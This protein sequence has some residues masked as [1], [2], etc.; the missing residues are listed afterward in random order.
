MGE[1]IIQQAVATRVRFR[2]LA[3]LCVLTFILYLDRVCVGQAGPAIR[4]DLQLSETQLGYVFASFTLAYGL[5]MAAAGRLGDRH[6]SRVVLVV[7]VLW[8]SVFTALTGACTGLAMLLIVRFI[9]GAGEAGALPNCA[10]II[11]R[12]FPAETRGMP[13][14]LL[15]TAALVGGAVAPFAAAQTMDLLDRRMAPWFASQFGVVPIGWRWTFAMFAVLGVVWAYFFW[16]NFRD[17]PGTHPDVNQAERE[18]IDRGRATGDPVQVTEPVPW[19]HVLRSRNVWLLG[20]IVSCASFASYLYLFWLPTYLQSGRGVGTVESG[21]LASLVL[22]GGALG[23]LLG[24]ILSD[25][26]NRWTGGRRRARSWIGALAMIAAGMVLL[27]SLQCDHPTTAAVV[28]GIGFLLMMLQVASW[29]GA[30]GDISGRHMA[31]LFG[32][33]NSLGVVGG[34]GAQIYFGWMADVQKAKGLS[35]RAQWDPALYDAVIV[36]CV[37]GLAWLLVNTNRSAVE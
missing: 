12:W 17:D 13:Q 28:I 15:N 31:T 36:L 34:M 5:F 22:A 11:N 21:N 10:R 23:S 27:G 30:V 32:L 35:G 25:R 8:W 6:G 19:R 1:P 9:F 16:R 4:R 33:M 3:W 29:W 24:G 7:I 20:F 37:G 26:V 18:L 2:V 14:G